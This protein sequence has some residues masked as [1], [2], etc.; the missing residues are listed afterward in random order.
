MRNICPAIANDKNQNR[1]V[2]IVSLANQIYKAQTPKSKRHLPGRNSN[3]GGKKNKERKKTCGLREGEKVVIQTGA[4][5]NPGS[6]TGERDEREMKWEAF[7][8]VRNN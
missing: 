6:I 7:H 1:C 2:S 5:P 8:A 4:N 3:T